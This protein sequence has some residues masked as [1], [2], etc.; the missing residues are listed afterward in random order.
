MRLSDRANRART[1]HLANESRRSQ[2]Q[3]VAARPAGTARE[4]KEAPNQARSTIPASKRTVG[5]QVGADAQSSQAQCPVPG[6]AVAQVRSEASR[7][8][9][10]VVRRAALHRRS[11]QPQSAQRSVPMRLSGSRATGQIEVSSHFAKYSDRIARCHWITV[12][13]SRPPAVRWPPVRS[14]STHRYWHPAAE[15]RESSV[16]DAAPEHQVRRRGPA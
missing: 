5:S 6:H 1:R 3:A 4:I 11:T 8:R 2:V 10:Q 15:L 9:S 12:Q 7:L 14:T 16:R 13:A